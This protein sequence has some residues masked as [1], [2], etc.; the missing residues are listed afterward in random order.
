MY[1]SH[2]SC[3]SI[4]EAAGAAEKLSLLHIHVP[5]REVMPF[6]NNFMGAA[7]QAWHVFHAPHCIAH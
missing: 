6:Y 5:C 4:P 1:M 3:S 7:N 2:K